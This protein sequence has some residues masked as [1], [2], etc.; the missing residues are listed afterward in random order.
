MVDWQQMVEGEIPEQHVVCICGHRGVVE[1]GEGPVVGTSISKNYYFGASPAQVVQ[2]SRD[3]W[4][5]IGSVDW[6]P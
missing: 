6:N 4:M 1:E 2:V 5:I 3:M